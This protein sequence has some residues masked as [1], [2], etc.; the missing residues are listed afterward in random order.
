MAGPQRSAGSL[1][2]SGISC[3]RM[4]T[5]E[6][7]NGLSAAESEEKVSESPSCPTLRPRGLYLPDSSVHGILQVGTLEWDALSFPRG[8]S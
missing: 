2:A 4:M 5:R 3:V 7:G 8:S 1:Q 6:A